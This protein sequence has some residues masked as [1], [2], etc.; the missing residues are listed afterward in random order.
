MLDYADIIVINKFDHRNSPDALRDVR[1]QYR[2]AHN[3]FKTADESLPVFG[4]MASNYYDRGLDVFFGAVIERL[5]NGGFVDWPP[6]VLP[7]RAG[8]ETTSRGIIP[9]ERFNYL[10][11]ISTAVRRYHAQ[12]ENS[13][14][15]LKELEAAETLGASGGADIRATAERLGSSAREKLDADIASSLA[16]WEE[17]RAAYEK[18]SLDVVIR[19][20]TISTPLHTESLSGLKIPLIA[21]PRYESRADLLRWLRK[22]NLPGY[23]PY[24][25]EFPLQAYRRGPQTSV[26][27][28][29][30]S[31]RT[32]RRFHY[33]TRNDSA[34]RIS[35]AFDSVTLYGQDPAPYPTYSA[36]S[37]RAA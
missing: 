17:T 4:T 34:K 28:E 6:A 12:T 33:L 26:C 30:F 3:D 25:A 14:A 1:K 23:F 22:E 16:R 37:A 27:G 19:G 18:E 13:A 31:G 35:T 7:E 20:K 11:E 15:V 29:G 36:K 8:N 32:N 5:R 9:P 2:R 21:L 10:S 24:T